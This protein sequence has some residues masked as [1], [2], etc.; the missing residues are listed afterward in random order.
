MMDMLKY[1]KA[2]DTSTFLVSKGNIEI[3][4]KLIQETLRILYLEKETDESEDDGIHDEM[5]ILLTKKY[6][7]LKAEQEKFQRGNEY[8]RTF[9]HTSIVCLVVLSFLGAGSYFMTGVVINKTSMAMNKLENRIHAILQ[10]D[11]ILMRAKEFYDNM[12]YVTK[13]KIVAAIKQDP[14][15]FY[16]AG[17]IH[18]E[19]ENISSAIT[20]FERALNMSP[21]NTKFKNKLEQVK[22]KLIESERIGGHG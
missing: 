5:E 7:A 19:E 20:Q 9:I 4:L 6:L 13:L 3:A 12:D 15:L 1:Q 11:R 16:R 2:I 21:D 22:K 18:L 17:L 10:P 8:F 14:E